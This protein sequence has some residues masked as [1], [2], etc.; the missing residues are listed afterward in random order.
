MH[1][2]RSQVRYCVQEIHKQLRRGGDFLFV[3]P[4]GSR[5][6]HSSEMQGLVRKFGLSETAEYLM[7]TWALA[8]GGPGKS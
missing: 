1:V 7:L 4:I 3:H 8:V 2:A 6:W 5:V